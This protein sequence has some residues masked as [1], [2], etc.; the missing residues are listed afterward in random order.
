MDVHNHLPITESLT[1]PGIGTAVGGIT[2]V[3]NIVGALPVIINIAVA[4][5]F[6]LMVVHKIY[7]M[8]KEFKQ[9]REYKR[10]K[11]APS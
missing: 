7:Q 9:D 6:T 8:V 10:N 2:V 5:Y 1:N 4:I 11:D 3:A